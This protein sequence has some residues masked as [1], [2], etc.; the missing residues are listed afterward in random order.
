[1]I[2]KVINYIRENGWADFWALIDAN[3]GLG[4]LEL[5]LSCN[6]FN[7][8]ATFWLN[9]RSFPF[10]QAF[11]FPIFVYG[12]PKILC[13]S[14]KMKIEGKVSSGMI[15]FNKTFYGAPSNMS[16]KSEIFNRGTIIFRGK[17]HIGTGSKLFVNQHAIF[18]IGNDFTIADQVNLGCYKH[19][20]CG[21]T[22]RIAH[23][24]QILD[25]NYHY[26]ANLT[27]KK[28]PR[29][30]API[31]IGS[32]CWIC[33]STTVYGGAVI[34]DNTIV[35]SNSLVKKDFSDI[36]A[37]SMLGGAPAKFLSSGFTRIYDP[38]LEGKISDFFNKNP[39]E[40]FYSISENDPI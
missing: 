9:I 31:T 33:N 2:N 5:I 26:V 1:M 12:R 28:V 13:L 7:P 18:E 23:R 3:Y 6:W 11:A 32:H 4:K 8:F 21:N 16:V 27:T 29:V 39:N 14:G 40:D 36:P 30:T 24:S 15:Q 38:K 35:A 37:Y 19:I 10:K 17:G 22:I 25:N 20:K 34:P